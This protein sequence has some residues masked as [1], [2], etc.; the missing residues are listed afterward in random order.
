[1]SRITH[2]IGV[3]RTLASYIHRVR[4]CCDAKALVSIIPS[5]LPRPGTSTTSTV[6]ENENVFSACVG[7]AFLGT[8]GSACDID[9]ADANAV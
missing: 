7:E 8:R 3:T 5:K 2:E 4:N 6:F 9:I 1:M